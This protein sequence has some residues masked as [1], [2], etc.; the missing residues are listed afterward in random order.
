MFTKNTTSYPEELSGD[1]TLGC[2]PYVENQ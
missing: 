2:D 1:P